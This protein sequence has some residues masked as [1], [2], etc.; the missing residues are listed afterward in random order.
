MEKKYP[1]DKHIYRQE[2]GRK[3]GRARKK[4]ARAGEQKGTLAAKLSLNIISL[5]LARFLFNKLLRAE[6]AAHGLEVT[7]SAFCDKAACGSRQEW[8]RMGGGSKR[9]RGRRKE[10][11]KRRKKMIAKNKSKG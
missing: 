6:L 2:P 5:S 9:Q 7:H 8:K 1:T 11:Y 4:R 10:M 3:R